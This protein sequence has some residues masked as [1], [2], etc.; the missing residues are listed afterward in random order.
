MPHC[1]GVINP[2]IFAEMQVFHCPMLHIKQ[3]VVLA[4]LC[5]PA[6]AANRL[7]D[8]RIVFQT[9]FGNIE[10]ALY[11]E[12]RLLYKFTGEVLPVVPYWDGTWSAQW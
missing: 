6:L 7:S 12:V 4:A 8:E 9:K 11:P 5:C 3:W 2:C 10:M 1:L